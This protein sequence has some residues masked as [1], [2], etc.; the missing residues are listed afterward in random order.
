MAFA[1]CWVAL[2]AAYAESN[3]QTGVAGKWA[4]DA[5]LNAKPGGGA[6][7]IREDF[8]R[9]RSCLA[10]SGKSRAPRIDF[11]GRLAGPDSN[12]GPAITME[13]K[14]DK[15]KLKGKITEVVSGDKFDIEAARVMGNKFDFVTN[16]KV[17]ETK[18]TTVYKGEL[19]DESTIILTRWTDSG[20]PADR[21]EDGTQA[22]LIFKRGK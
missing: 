9:G 13:I 21:K 12:E 5:T 22:A 11:N 8:E 15:A 20:K 2:A 18:I 3:K 14:L 17:S 6:G 19:I 16:K 7:V 4:T 10:T 1:A